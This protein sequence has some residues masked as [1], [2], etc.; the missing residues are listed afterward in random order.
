V[1]STEKE[2]PQGIIGI[3]KN[4]ATTVLIASG[5]RFLLG[6]VLANAMRE[7]ALIKEIN[8]SHLKNFLF[9]PSKAPTI[10]EAHTPER[11]KTPPMMLISPES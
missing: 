8:L 7:K 3:R 6:I 1:S 10:T 2:N 11:M 5:T 4:P 9:L